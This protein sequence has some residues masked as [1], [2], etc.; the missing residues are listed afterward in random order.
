MK[1]DIPEY[2]VVGVYVA[3]V[4]REGEENEPWDAYLINEN[5]YALDTVF[6]TSNGEG[7]VDGVKKITSTMRY[8]YMQIPPKSVQLIESII[9][10]LFHLNNSYWVTYFVNGNIHDKKFVFA[11]HT[12]NESHFT[13]VPVLNKKGVLHA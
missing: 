8:R 10:D 13:M 1:K 2:K 11:A 3:I 4:P 7:E 12:I 6:V 5:D 9:T